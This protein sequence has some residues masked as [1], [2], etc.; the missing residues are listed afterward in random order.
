MNDLIKYLHVT[1][2]TRFDAR[3]NPNAVTQ[4]SYYILNHGPFSDEYTEG[5][6]TP[7]AVNAGFTA[8]ID[9]LRAV[10]ALP[11]GS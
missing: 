5:K 3:G 10:G 1:S 11:V 7:E 9:K 4:Y 8:R 2:Q 6:D